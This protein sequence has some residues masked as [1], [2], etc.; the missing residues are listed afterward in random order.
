MY[1]LSYASVLFGRQWKSFLKFYYGTGQFDRHAFLNGINL[2][3]SILV[4]SQS[5]FFQLINTFMFGRALFTLYSSNALIQNDIYSYDMKPIVISDFHDIYRI[6]VLNCSATKTDLI[7]ETFLSASFLYN[8]AQTKYSR[9]VNHWKFVFPQ[10]Q[11]NDKFLFYSPQ[12]GLSNQLIALEKAIIVARTMNRILVLPDLYINGKVI[13]RATIF[14]DD[15]GIYVSSGRIISLQSYQA[16]VSSG[17]TSYPSQLFNLSVIDLKQ[18][19]PSLNYFKTIGMGNIP[20][21]QTPI[22]LDQASYYKFGKSHIEEKTIAFVS[23]FASW[24]DTGTK[25]EDA[26]YRNV[27]SS[28]LSIEKQW[29]KK[30][31]HD[32]IASNQLNNDFICA[33]VRRDDFNLSCAL[34]DEEMRT[35]SPRVWVKRLYSKRKSCWVDETV[36]FNTI[37]IVRTHLNMGKDLDKKLNVY[38]STDDNEFISQ[39]SV[40]S[41]RLH[42]AT[43]VMLPTLLSMKEFIRGSFSHPLI[44]QNVCSGAKLLILNSFSTFS[45]KIYEKAKRKNPKIEAIAWTTSNE[46]IPF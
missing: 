5:S 3:E 21:T 27:I 36:L 25:V 28:L 2:P 15:I 11:A 20:V 30:L 9:I 41:Q 8:I 32:V 1:P 39:L 45:A 34:Y 46:I 23:L 24:F 19:I 42:G 18:A 40:E 4:Q 16:L 44:D 37:S 10:I 12:F 33:H 26:Y 29:I 31:S 13:P 6:P 43:F 22:S 38:V 17:I 35:K 7:H 14:Q